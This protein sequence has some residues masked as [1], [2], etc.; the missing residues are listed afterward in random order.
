MKAGQFLEAYQDEMK[1]VFGK[2]M[3]GLALYNRKSEDEII[4]GSS[5]DVIVLF[6]KGFNS[7][8]ERTNILSV[9]LLMEFR[10]QIG[11][12]PMPMVERDNFEFTKP[13]P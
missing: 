9:G 3:K 7:N 2:R 13:N 12:A 8:I 4:K 10:H 11:V 5:L 6:E 1:K